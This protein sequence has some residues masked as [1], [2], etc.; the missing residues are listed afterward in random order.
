[1]DATG[2]GVR[3][4]LFRS[5]HHH[6]GGTGRRWERPDKGLECLPSAGRRTDRDNER[7]SWFSFAVPA[8]PLIIGHRRTRRSCKSLFQR[9]TPRSEERRVGKEWTYRT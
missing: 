4:V 6:I 9:F 2:T 1:R 5:H 8:V 3:R 7:L